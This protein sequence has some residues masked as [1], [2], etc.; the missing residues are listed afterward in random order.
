ML[1]C[2][3]IHRDYFTFFIECVSFFKGAVKGDTRFIKDPLMSK[4]VMAI[5]ELGGLRPNQQHLMFR[6]DDFDA[7]ISVRILHE[8]ENHPTTCIKASTKTL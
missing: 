6:G 8:G 7:D 4:N 2:I 1:V 5:L 3:R